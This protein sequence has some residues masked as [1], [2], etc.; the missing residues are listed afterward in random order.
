[1]S[2]LNDAALLRYSRHILLPQIDVE[3]QRRLSAARA[4]VVG[5]G[6]LGSPVAL[7]L[8]SSG[9]GRITLADDDQVELS[10]LQ[11]QI[12]HDTASL[13]QNKAESAARRM[14][15]MNPGVC[16]EVLTQRLALPD[17]ASCWPGMMWWW[18]V[19]TILPP[20]MR[21]TARR[22]RAACP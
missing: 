6:G 7:Y 3:G 21:S 1:M 10:N 4:L 9:V 15:G 22:L 19:R 16:V 11:R 13:G 17:F 14:T 20:D 18:T 5:A 12:A 8:A 2:E